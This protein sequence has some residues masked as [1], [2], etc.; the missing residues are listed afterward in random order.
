MVLV[1]QSSACGAIMVAICSV[2]DIIRFIRLA[3]QLQLALRSYD[4]SCSEYALLVDQLQSIVVL[5]QSYDA[6]ITAIRRITGQD[7][8]D[9]LLPYITSIVES[10]NKATSSLAKFLTRL[11]SFAIRKRELQRSPSASAGVRTSLAGKIRSIS[12]GVHDFWQS[13]RWTLSATR[14]EARQLFALLAHQNVIVSN[15]FHE[16]TTLAH[17]LSL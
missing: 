4:G 7:H 6:T 9:A 1:R 14:K 12:S 10:A 15:K 11:E 13:L 17:A 16:M 2:S 5:F 3:Y 8:D